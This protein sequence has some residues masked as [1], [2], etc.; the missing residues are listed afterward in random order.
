V[1]SSMRQPNLGSSPR[2]V[3]VSRMSSLSSG[4]VSGQIGFAG[5]RSSIGKRCSV[6]FESFGCVSSRVSNPISS[7]CVSI[8][9]CVAYSGNA[10]V[11]LRKVECASGPSPKI[12]LSK[13]FGD[14]RR[15]AQRQ[16]LSRMSE[17]FVGPFSPPS[18]CGFEY[19][20]R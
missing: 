11:A 16:V 3:L 8:P 20:L 13:A 7:C 18:G 5:D 2:Q 4:R 1:A 17:R 6:S 12:A 10:F 15:T 9:G 14:L 19:L